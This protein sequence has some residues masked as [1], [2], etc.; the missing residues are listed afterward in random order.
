MRSGAERRDERLG[1]GVEVG[2]RAE[3]DQE[4]PVVAPA[5]EEPDHERRF[6]EHGT[7]DAARCLRPERRLASPQPEQ[8]TMERDGTLVPLALG[9]IELAAHKDRRVGRIGQTF[10]CLRRRDAREL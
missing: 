1:H 10:R 7:V 2:A 4:Q 8:I 6:R 9:P 5:A 3:I